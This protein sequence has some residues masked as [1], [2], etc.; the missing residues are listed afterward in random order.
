MHMY[1]YTNTRAQ[2]CLAPHVD[3]I[4]YVKHLCATYIHTYIHYITYVLAY[5]LAYIHAYITDNA[6]Y[7]D[8]RALLYH[9]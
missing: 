6:T 5:I 7:I 9:I 2:P 4:I 1:M 8:F 3:M